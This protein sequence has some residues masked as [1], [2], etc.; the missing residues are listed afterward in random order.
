MK[1]IAYIHEQSSCM[2]CISSEAGDS[3]ADNIGCSCRGPIFGSQHSHGPQPS[4]NLAPGIPTPSSG[5]HRCRQ[6]LT[7]MK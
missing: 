2:N 6:T 3:A 1:N 5:K 7:H 4:V